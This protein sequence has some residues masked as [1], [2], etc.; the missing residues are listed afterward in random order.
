MQVQEE[1][2]RYRHSR[3]QRG[4]RIHAEMHS[5]PDERADDRKNRRERNAEISAL[6]EREA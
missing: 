2:R 1:E 4:E 3:R 5:V 6:T